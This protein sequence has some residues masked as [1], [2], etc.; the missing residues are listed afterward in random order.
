M[1]TTG[2]LTKRKFKYY[3]KF[4]NSYNYNIGFVF[5]VVLRMI[6]QWNKITAVT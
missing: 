6:I 1:S 5:H 2:K 3:I 4:T